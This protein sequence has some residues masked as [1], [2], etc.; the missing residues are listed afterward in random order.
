MGGEVDLTE[1]MLAVLICE[2][3]HWTWQEYD[4]QP[5]WFIDLIVSKMRAEAEESHK[6]AKRANLKAGRPR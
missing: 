5:T 4:A 1:T 2:K 6:A 3:F